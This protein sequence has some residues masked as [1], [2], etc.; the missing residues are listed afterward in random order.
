MLIRSNIFARTL[1][2]HVNVPSRRRLFVV[3]P[4][5]LQPSPPLA[6][7]GRYNTSATS[8]RGHVQPPQRLKDRNVSEY[9]FVIFFYSRSP[10]IVRLS[11]I[12]IHSN[13]FIA[14]I[15]SNLAIAS[16]ASCCRG[17]IRRVRLMRDHL[18]LLS[19]PATL[20]LFSLAR[21]AH[22]HEPPWPY[23]LP[24]AAKYYPEDET[25]IQRWSKVQEKLTMQTPC[26][27]RKM[28]HDPN[29]KFYLDYWELGLESVQDP[30]TE[31]AARRYP[32]QHEVLEQYP[33]STR[34]E[35][36]SAP[37]APHVYH[38]RIGFSLF[39]RSIF[40]RDFQCPS[41]TSVC[42]N[43]GSDLCCNTGQT[44]INTSEGPGC[45][46]NGQSCGDTVAGCDT[47]AGYTSCPNSNNGGCCVPGAVCY[48][49]GCAFVGTLTR[50]STL[51]VVTV[52]SGI[53]YTQSATSATHSTTMVSDHTTTVTISEQGSTVTQTV[54]APTTIVIVPSVVQSSCSSGFSSCASS[55]GG[56]CCRS[57]QSCATDSCIDL[58]TISTSTATAAPPVRPTTS[59][60]SSDPPMTVTITTATSPIGQSC[61]TGFY[62]CS[63]VYLGN[64][65]QVGRNC[66]TSSC[67]STASTDIVTSGLTIG[68]AVSTCATGWSSCAGSVGGGCC[69][70]GYNCGTASCANPSGGATETKQT[71]N[72]V[73]VVTGSTWWFAALGVT[74]ALGMICL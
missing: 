25:H 52:T 10:S 69:P 1:I 53:S 42:S 58:S 60:A 65:C 30:D 47:A 21:C 2:A 48:Q 3:G 46:P 38:D 29:E 40:S 24:R 22:A 31:Y 49:S 62:M 14:S 28:G 8:C 26:G 64:C 39:G 72:S 37:Y 41:G 19:L 18:G 67:P 54:V 36:L 4:S 43:I 71:S 13:L 73:A 23:N 27:V 56:G 59:A 51:P 45:C 16:H 55:L 20:L 35:L 11:R 44:C 5:S 74:A 66:D 9:P 57:G 33:N 68:V 63:A 7:G 50:I 12:A 70:S 32:A 15:H 34:V 6:V 17:L 61:P